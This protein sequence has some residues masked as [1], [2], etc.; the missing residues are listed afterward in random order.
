MR[1]K[2]FLAAFF[3]GC[4]LMGA[5]NVPYIGVN[6]G[7]AELKTSIGTGNFESKHNDTHYTGTVGQYVGENGRVSLSYTYVEPTGHVQHSDGVSLAFDY[8]IPVVENTISLYLGP[9]IGYTR[10]EEE[11]AG[12]KLDL[13]G[14]HYGAQAGA[15]VRIVDNIEIEGGYRYLVETGKDTVLGVDVNADDLRMGYIGVN[16]RF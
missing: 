9:V 4:E 10:L 6:I 7:N 12:V 2:I 16:F 13:N 8:I 15:I 1:K 3:A 11:A 5:N 14:M